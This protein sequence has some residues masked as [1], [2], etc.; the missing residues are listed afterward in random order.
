MKNLLLVL[1]LLIS[2]IAFGQIKRYEIEATKRFILKGDTLKNTTALTANDTLMATKDYVL[3]VAGAGNV[4]DSLSYNVNTGNIV[5]WY[6]GSKIDSVSTDNR[7]L[8]IADSTD[9]I[10][11]Y[12]FTTT[13]NEMSVQTV[14]E[15]RLP[16]ST[17]VAGRIAGAVECTDYP[18]GWILTAGASPVDLIIQHDMGTRRVASVTVWAVDGTYEQQLFNTAA[19]NGIKGRYESNQWLWIQSLA[20]IQKPIKIYIT[21]R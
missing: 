5:W 7:Y 20:T 11:P 16:S 3:S 4:W 2:S 13:L 6:A 1:F 10:T 19:Y 15:I 12:E 21:F 8:K 9:Y 17:T 18:T 14:F